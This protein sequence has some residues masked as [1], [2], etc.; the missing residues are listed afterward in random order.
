MAR[1]SRVNLRWD[2][3]AGAAD[4]LVYRDGV[5]LATVNLTTFLDIQVSPKQAY[6]Y[7]ITAR[8]AG[9]ASS[10]V[11]KRVSTAFEAADRAALSTKGWSRVLR[12]SRRPERADACV[13]RPHVH[14]L[15]DVDV[16][17]Q[18]LGIFE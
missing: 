15:G 9:G 10:P 11:S 7:T 12:P 4:Y 17:A 16:G 8:N 6:T 18:R 5:Y 2:S 3:A 13:Q 14:R 1:G